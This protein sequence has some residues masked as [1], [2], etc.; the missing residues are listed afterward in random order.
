MAPDMIWR[1]VRAMRKRSDL[2]QAAPRA[3]MRALARSIV[4]QLAEYGVGRRIHPLQVLLVELG[5]LH[6]LA[7]Q[8]G[9]G[10]ASISL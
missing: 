2:S 9:L 8:V 3:E 7:L 6:S 5:F 4:E 1:R 10:N